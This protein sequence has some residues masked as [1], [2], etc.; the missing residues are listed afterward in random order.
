MKLS[1]HN[2]IMKNLIGKLVIFGHVTHTYRTT[3]WRAWDWRRR[4]GTSSSYQMIRGASSTALRIK[5]GG[6]MILWRSCV[7]GLIYIRLIL[8][9]VKQIGW[10]IQCHI[11]TLLFCF[12][13]V[14]IFFSF[15]GVN[16]FKFYFKSFLSLFFLFHRAFCFH[17]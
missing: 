6:T 13:E 15:V 3:P 4:N 16:F 2:H 7:F 8:A 9:S 10:R 11:I 12:D 14:W 5:V 17:P 1:Y